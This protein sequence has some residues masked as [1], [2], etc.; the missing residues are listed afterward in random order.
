MAW[1]L[2]VRLGHGVPVSRRAIR[3]LSGARNED[4]LVLDVVLALATRLVVQVDS[5]Q[6]AIRAGRRIAFV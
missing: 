2:V 4:T 5:G 3:H 6:D 1:H